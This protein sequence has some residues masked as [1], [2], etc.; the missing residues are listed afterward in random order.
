M[1]EQDSA[2]VDEKPLAGGRNPLAEMNAADFYAAGCDG[3]SVVIIPAEED[4][5]EGEEVSRGDREVRAARRCV[6]AD[7]GRSTTSAGARPQ[8]LTGWPRRVDHREVA[9]VERR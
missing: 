7:S 3:D 2:M 9:A 4:D 8:R 6:R 5:G 1:V